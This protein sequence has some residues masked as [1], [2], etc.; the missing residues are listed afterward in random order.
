MGD[1]PSRR[2]RCRCRYPT[3]RNAI[4]THLLPVGP[5][6]EVDITEGTAAHPLGDAVLGDGGLHRPLCQTEKKMDRSG[7]SLKNKCEKIRGG[8]KR[9]TPFDDGQT[10]TIIL[11][12]YKSA[13]KH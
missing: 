4:S 1:S 3:A 8:M 13:K 9:E 6:A 7:P 2:R 12:K 10:K 11:S 5:D